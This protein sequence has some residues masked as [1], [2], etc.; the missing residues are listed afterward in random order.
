M[1]DT[2]TIIE[3]DE[4]PFGG[5]LPRPEALHDDPTAFSGQLSRSLIDWR[6]RGYRVVW[7]EVPIEKSSLIP[8]AVEAGFGFHHRLVQM[9]A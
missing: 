5:V 4:N 7:L 6:E 8:V 2:A 1:E 9:P 3:A